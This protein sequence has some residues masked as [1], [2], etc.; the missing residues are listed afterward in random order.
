MSQRLDYFSVAG[1]LFKPM[2]A[3]ENLFKNSTLEYSVVELVK[4]R[5]S[6]INGCAFCIH[7]HSHEMRAMAKARTGCIC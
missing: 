1:D 3:Q 2:M 5:A 4:L 7:M 6:Q